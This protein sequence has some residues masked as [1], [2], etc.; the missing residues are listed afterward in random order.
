M[1]WTMRGDRYDYAPADE[2]SIDL[3][4]REVKST[5]VH[6]LRE[7]PY[8]ADGRIRVSVSDGVVQ[9]GGVVTS[10]EARAVAED[11]A[12]TIPG[13]TDVQNQLEVRKAA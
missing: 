4:D 1:A 13:V 12:L 2:T 10:R 3:P 6:R 9:L 7:N 11:D 8:T 5:V